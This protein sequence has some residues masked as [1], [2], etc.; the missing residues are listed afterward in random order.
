VTV[1]ADLDSGGTLF[2]TAGKD[3]ATLRASAEELP[4]HGARSEQIE[5]MFDTHKN[6][7]GF[8]MK[9]EA[10]YSAQDPAKKVCY[11]QRSSAVGANSD[12]KDNYGGRFVRVRGA[13]EAMCHLVFGVLALTAIQLF[14]LL[15]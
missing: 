4:K 2:V 5:A 12:L 10:L 7:L 13:I 9:Y 15:E 6:T 8:D 3:A 1:F 11:R 14:E